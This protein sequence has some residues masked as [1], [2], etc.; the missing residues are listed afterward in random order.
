MDKLEAKPLDKTEAE[1]FLEEMELDT[2]IQ[3]LL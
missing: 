3:E 1:L 2:N